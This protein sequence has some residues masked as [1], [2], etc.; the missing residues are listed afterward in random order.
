MSCDRGEQLQLYA[1]RVLRPDEALA[2]EAHVVHVLGLPAGVGVACVRSSTRFASWPTDVLRPS[3]RLWERL[4]QRI[5]AEAGLRSPAVQEPPGRAEPEWEEVAPGISCKLLARIRS[6][7][8]SACSSASRRE[9]SI[10]LTRTRDARNCICSTAS[11]GSTTG[12]SLPGDYNR[13]EAGT[14]DA[15]VW[16]ETGCT[17]VLITSARDVLRA[18]R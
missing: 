12:S 3:R 5:A 1:L 2:I 13:A 15:R 4:S 17:C 8:S 16:S 6:G 9:G 7:T 10:R 14:S 18:P 11:C